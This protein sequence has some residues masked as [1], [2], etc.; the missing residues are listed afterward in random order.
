MSDL[1]LTALRSLDGADVAGKRVLVRAD[2]NVPMMGN[3]VSDSTRIERFLPTLRNLIGRGAKVIVLSHFGRPKGHARPEMSLRP[4]ADELSRLLGE[5]VV[6][7]QEPVGAGAAKVIAS[8]GEGDVALMENTRFYSGEEANDLGFAN[9]L[10]KLGDVYVNDAFSC[11]HR[12]HASTEGLVHYLPSFV[13]PQMMSE[14]NALRNALEDPERPVV[15]VVG[16]AKISSKIPVLKNLVHK[17]DILIIGGGMANTFLHAQG[18]PVSGSLH[19]PD[20]AAIAREIMCEAAN[21]DC[22][23]IL[24][25]DVV[26][27]EAFAEDARHGIYAVVEVPSDRMILDFGPE[28]VARL[29]KQLDCCSTLLWNGP[30]GAFEIRPF[31]EGTFAL[32]RHAAARTTAGKLVSVAGG[33]DTVAALNM[34]GVTQD[35]SYVSTAGG[36]FL[37]WL[38]GR[39]LPGVVALAR[40]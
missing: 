7:V 40:G 1:D 31:G 4:I 9:D 39:E 35:F 5:P 24:P 16:G 33:G 23:I 21:T 6:F 15:A 18:M 22:V 38:E 17:V 14:I 19:E 27:A 12:A 32:A 20:F 34:A 36:A 3:V 26:A 2:L 30:I 37:E 28:S 25:S 29:E 13:G 8:L 10:A 11:A